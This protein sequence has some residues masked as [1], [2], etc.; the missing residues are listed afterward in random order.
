MIHK[1]IKGFTIDSANVGIFYKG[2]YMNQYT[3]DKLWNV[4]LFL[5]VAYVIIQAVRAL[6]N[7]I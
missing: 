5:C 3:K 7:S 6:L 1:L 4:V 2:F